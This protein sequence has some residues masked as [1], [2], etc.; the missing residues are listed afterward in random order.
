M[1]LGHAPLE[2]DFRAG[3]YVY[4]TLYWDVSHPTEANQEV[5][6][7]VTDADGG[8]YARLDVPLGSITYPPVGTSQWP[9]EGAR[10]RE[11][12]LV[13]LPE[14]MGDSFVVAIAVDDAVPRVLAE[15]TLTP[16]RI[17]YHGIIQP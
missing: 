12:Y 14:V 15:V 8:E 7:L 4:L 11:S 6:V 17:T 1:L 3:G 13:S 10:L 5:A 16:P 9:S 2:T